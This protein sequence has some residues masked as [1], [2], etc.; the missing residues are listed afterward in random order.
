MSRDRRGLRWIIAAVVITV[1][2]L[3]TTLAVGR[4]F[5]NALLTA[6][7]FGVIGATVLVFLPDR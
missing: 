6:V 7:V 3:A 4:T 5:S 1:A 2:T